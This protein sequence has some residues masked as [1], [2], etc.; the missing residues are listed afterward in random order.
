MSI[1]SLSFAQESPP[2]LS[3][4]RHFLVFVDVLD[5]NVHVDA[6]IDAGVNVDVV[7]ADYTD[8]EVDAGGGGSR[9]QRV[10]F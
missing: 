3:F 4:R 2:I 9:R 1:S 8:V 6:G 7:I 10:A 5:F